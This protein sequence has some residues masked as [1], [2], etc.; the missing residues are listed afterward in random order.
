MTAA[1]VCGALAGGMLLAAMPFLAY[2]PLV[3]AAAPHTD[4]EP[5]YGGQLGMVGDQHIELRRWR[6][7]VEVFVSDARRR[8]LQPRQ[9][10]IVFDGATTAAL[11]WNG[12]H[13]VGADL[14]GARAAETVVV[15]EDGT[16]LA[17][18]FDLS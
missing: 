11:T 13:F 10:W 9:A 8:P 18:S 12:H 14:A 1:R 15:L 2:A 5:R 16:R 4:H 6:G 7:A 17:L 3:G